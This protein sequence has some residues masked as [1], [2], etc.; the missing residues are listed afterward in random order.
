MKLNEVVKKIRFEL[1][2]SQEG[3]AR[4][5]QVGFTSVNRWG[6]GRAKPN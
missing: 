3:L 2:L 5:L 6:N 1:G 4:D